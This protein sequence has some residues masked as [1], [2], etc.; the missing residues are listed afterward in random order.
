MFKFLIL[1]ALL[2][3]IL[4]FAGIANDWLRNKMGIQAP[5]PPPPQPIAPPP[6]LV[7]D[8]Y[9]M[10]GENLAHCVN[11][12]SNCG[13][14]ETQYPE[15]TYVPLKERVRGNSKYP[16]VWIYEHQRTSVGGINI[17]NL[18]NTRY[19]TINVKNMIDILNR[20]IEGHCIHNGCFPVVI[21]AAKN[22]GHGR[23]RL[24][25]APAPSYF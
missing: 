9:E 6:E 16:V 1:G 8:I 11:A 14:L 21:V 18:G 5:P 22:L 25:V 23:V 15:Q 3:A 12:S 2:I 19:N 7:R 10:V 17:H 13:L 24:A 20:S 4:I